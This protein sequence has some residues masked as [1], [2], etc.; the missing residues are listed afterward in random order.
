MPSFLL[1]SACGIHFGLQTSCGSSSRPLWIQSSSNQGEIEEEVKQSEG[2]IILF[3]DEIHT[4]IGSQAFDAANILKPA[5]ARRE[6]QCIGALKNLFQAVE[7]AEPSVEETIQTLKEFSKKFEAHH[8]VIY[9]D[10][11]L[12]VAA[13]AQLSHKNI[14]EGFLP[15][16]ALDILDKAGA[17]VQLLQEQKTPQEAQILM[18]E[19]I[20][21]TVAFMT[22]ISL[23]EES[24]E[25]SPKALEFGK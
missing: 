25:D 9:T 18:E 1:L 14:S 2:A 23:E 16:K 19:N 7:L 15:D 21:E 6:F 3:I 17:R 10:K 22:G 12:M 11:A 4:L 8:N 24:L 13:A 5:L 20:K